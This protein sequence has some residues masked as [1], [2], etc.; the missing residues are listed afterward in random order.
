MTG[1]P[2]GRR[3]RGKGVRGELEF[4]AEVR[5]LFGVQARRGKQYSGGPESPDVKTDI[6]GLYVEV[7]RTEGLSVYAALEQAEGDRDWDEIPAVAHRRNRKRWV[8][9]VYLDDLPELVG[10]LRGLV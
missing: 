2:H 4:A 8:F 5:R 9:C 10:K 3:S 7:K 6:E 1:P